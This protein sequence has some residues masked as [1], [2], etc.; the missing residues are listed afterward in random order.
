MYAHR[1]ELHF[2]EE[3]EFSMKHIRIFM[4]TTLLSFG[5][6]SAVH[7]AENGNTQYSPGSAQFFAAGVPPFEGFYFLSQTSYFSADRTNDS[8]GHELPIDFHIKAAVETLRLLYVS[9]VHIGDAQLWG[10]IVLPLVHLDLSTAFGSDKTTA[11][12]DATVTTGLAW[13][14]DQNQTIVFGID[15]GV[16]IGN[17]DKNA[18][19]TG[20]LNHWSVQPTLGYHYSDPQGLELA[21]TARFI[22]NSEN[23]DTHY[24]SGDEFV[25]DY[26]VGWNFNKVRLGAVGYYLKQFTDDRGPNVAA[27]G[28]RGEGLAVG[29]S[30]T[31]S[32][33]PGMQVSASWQKDVVAKNRAEGNTVWVNFATKF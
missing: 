2:P 6:L 23:T 24:K 7:A 1:N 19:V 8:K 32:F 29:P 20:G 13:H 30:V 9:D 16:P 26:A 33:N 28:H 14:P 3:E 11:F 5:C 17:Y 27:D 22:F 12:A 4:A 21:G 31:Y 18:L 10:Q 25:L 15:V